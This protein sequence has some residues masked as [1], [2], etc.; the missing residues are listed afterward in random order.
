MGN[1]QA[2]FGSG[3]GLYRAKP[4][5]GFLATSMRDYTG[6]TRELASTAKEAINF[7]VLNPCVPAARFWRIA[8]PPPVTSLGRL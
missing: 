1:K 6:I 2:H 3:F 4:K 5:V 8:P 7:L